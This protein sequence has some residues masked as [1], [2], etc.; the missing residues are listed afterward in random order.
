MS[1]ASFHLNIA[2]A[3]AAIAPKSID[4]TRV[5]EHTINELSVALPKL[6]AVHANE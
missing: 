4:K 2:I 1:L 5:I 6:P 3:Y